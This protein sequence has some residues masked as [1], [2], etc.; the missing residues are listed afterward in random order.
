MSTPDQT[1]EEPI[2]LA[3]VGAAPVRRLFTIFALYALAGIVVYRG[4]SAP[5]S[6]LGMVWLVLCCAVLFWA[7]QAVRRASA[8][9]I[10]LTPDDLR[11]TSG[12]V[13]AQI[14]DIEKMHRGALALKPS[15]GFTLQMREAQTAAWAPGLWWRFGRMV[16]VGGLPDKAATR[17]MAEA[18]ATLLAQRD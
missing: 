14:A 9:V 7:A 15:N 11:D 3:R 4:V 13:L 8:R 5:I 17:F 12:V 18:L 10:I 2:I 1:P 16:G 6:L